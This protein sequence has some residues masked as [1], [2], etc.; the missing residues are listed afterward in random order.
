MAVELKAPRILFMPKV[1][2]EPMEDM[3]MDGTP[4]A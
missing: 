2:T 3:I 1:I 4:T